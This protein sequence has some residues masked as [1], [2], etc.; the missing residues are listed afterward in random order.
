MT[1]HLS[2]PTT[3]HASRLISTSSSRA[4]RGR[5]TNSSSDSLQGKRWM[6]RWRVLHYPA[7]QQVLQ[8]KQEQ[9]VQT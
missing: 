1:M 2:A 4:V 9:K 6:W 3:S 7:G 8:H 5:L